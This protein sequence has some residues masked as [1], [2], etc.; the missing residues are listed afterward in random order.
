M[1][2]MAL[3]WASVCMLLLGLPAAAGASQEQHC[4]GQNYAISL[5]AHTGADSRFASLTEPAINNRG[6]VAFGAELRPGEAA[7]SGYFISD[8]GR[9][10]SIFTHSAAD[11][12]VP[13][14]GLTSP[15]I[16]DGGDVAFTGVANGT[17]GVFTG[18][19]RG[20]TRV[21]T[22]S[23]ILPVINNRREVS[24]SAYDESLPGWATH[25]ARGNASVNI[26]EGFLPNINDAG[27]VVFHRRGQIMK[28]QDGV[29]TPVVATPDFYSGA[30]INNAGRV[31]YAYIEWAPFLSEVRTIF[32][33]E[34]TRIAGNHTGPFEIMS[35]RSIN[36]RGQVVFWS[37]HNTM[38]DY[39]IYTGPNVVADKVV[40][41]G[42]A[43]FGSSVT[44]LGQMHGGRGLNDSGQ[45]AFLA[46]LADGRTVIAVATPCNRGASAPS[47]QLPGGGADP[48]EGLMRVP[49]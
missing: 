32:N 1:R 27:A 29:V 19:V 5:L 30:G 44:S 14:Y 40:Q 39:G 23:A 6:A 18:D 28:W 21:F 2:V 25:V 13:G 12:A 22:E 38:A 4:A 26:G 20:V 31:A 48:G 41:T 10:S 17:A 8:G 34:I 7:I 16:N 37:I 11:A 3:A 46:G 15:G 47:E 9:V 33:G 35:T 45:V 24:F 49:F 43:L 36:N 42:D